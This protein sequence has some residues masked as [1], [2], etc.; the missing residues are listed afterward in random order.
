MSFCEGNRI[1]AYSKK[2][3]RYISRGSSHSSS[4][5]VFVLVTDGKEEGTGCRFTWVFMLVTDETDVGN[6]HGSYREAAGYG[7]LREVTR[8]FEIFIISSHLLSAPASLCTDESE[9]RTPVGAL[10]F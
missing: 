10:F 7:E 8:D 2:A 1:L 9:I 5:W 3:T 4:V 6:G